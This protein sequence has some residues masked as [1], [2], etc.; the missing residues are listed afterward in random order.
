MGTI[1]RL[2]RRDARRIAVRAQLLDEPRPT[3]VVDVMRRLTVVQLD[4]TAAVAPSADLV[5]VSRLGSTY[6]SAELRRALDDHSLVD[7]RGMLRPSEDI[8]L[9]RADMADWPGT[10]ELRNYK[11]VQR[12]W[13]MNSSIIATFL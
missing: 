12:D 7:L 5:L 9:Y 8:A 1:H 11:K 3:D 2:S 6:A 10:G 13:V 4:W